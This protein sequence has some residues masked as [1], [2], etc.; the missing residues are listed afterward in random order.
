MLRLVKVSE[1]HLPAVM[2]VIDEYRNDDRPY[3]R[4]SVNTLIEA[5]DEGNAVAWLEQKQNEENGVNLP[6]G[7][8]SSTYYWLM[9][10][11]E[12][13]GSFTLRHKLTETL[14]NVG[15]NIGYIILPSK[16]GKGYASAG[17][18]LCLR[19]AGKMGLERVL[20]TCNARNKASFAVITKAMNKYGGEMLPDVELDGGFEHRVWIN[21]INE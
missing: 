19:E 9:D 3:G 18:G 6:A 12:Y 4:G 17:M 14:M 13:V 20:I 2:K 5:I 16:R 15:G 21:T 1:K 10:G 11:K 7:Y 8:V